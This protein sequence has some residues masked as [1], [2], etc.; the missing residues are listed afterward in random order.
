MIDLVVVLNDKTKDLFPEVEWRQYKDAW[1]AEVDHDL[2]VEIAKVARE[3]GLSVGE[4]DASEPRL[5]HEH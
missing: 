1:V 2:A 5:R 4:K 3:V